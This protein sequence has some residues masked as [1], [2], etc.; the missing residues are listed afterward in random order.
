MANRKNKEWDPPM[1][2]KKAKKAL[3]RIIEAIGERLKASNIEDILKNKNV[4][5]LTYIKKIQE[6]DDLVII[7][8]KGAID[9]D[10]VPF[11]SDF[12]K[13]NPGRTERYLNK[14]ILVDFKE[15]THID[16]STLASLI[17]LLKELKIREKK[18]GII[19]ATLFLKNHLN[20]AK[21]ESIVKLYRSE[22][23]ASKDLS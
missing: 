14:H 2:F 1:D 5:A 17:Q 10:A 9:S 4:K 19:N 15:V 21:L 13:Q 7:R 23:V 22:K 6:T 16:S 12:G 20:I 11:L 3:E 8:L 18:L